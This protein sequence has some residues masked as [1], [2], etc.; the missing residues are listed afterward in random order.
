VDEAGARAAEAEI[1]VA[2][3]A[4]DHGED[5]GEDARVP[6]E[7][8]VGAPDRV[9][10]VAAFI[11]DHREKRRA[12]MEGKAMVVTVS[13]DI[14]GRLY[15]A[16]EALRPAWHDP[17]DDKGVMKLVATG[18]PDDEE[19]LACYI[20]TEQG[21]K[22]PAERFKHPADEFRLAIVVGTWL[23]GFDCPPA[24]T[25]DLDKPLAGP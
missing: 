13:R 23:T 7:E 19:P 12:A 14:A 10:R 21:R 3:A 15:E 25:M 4:S 11:V 6:L 16:I 17:D 2:A 1:A 8:L 5:V 18:G 20:R 9:G 22:R 24:H